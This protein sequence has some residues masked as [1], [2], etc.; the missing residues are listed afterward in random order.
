MSIHTKYSLLKYSRSYPPDDPGHIAV[1]P[2]SAD[3]VWQHFSFPELY[4]S[5]GK[6]DKGEL[7]TAILKIHWTKDTLLTSS[8]R[9]KGRI[10]SFIV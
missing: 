10:G 4:L 8:T 7:Q 9:R 2:T 6:S 3:A 1:K 5:F